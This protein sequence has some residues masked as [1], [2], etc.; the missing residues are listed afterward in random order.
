[1]MIGDDGGRD[2]VPLEAKGAEGLDY[3]LMLGAP[4]PPLQ[5]IP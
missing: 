2:A 1:M 3:E 4:S 5:R